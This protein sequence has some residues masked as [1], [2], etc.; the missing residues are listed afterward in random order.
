[1]SQ[2]WQNFRELGSLNIGHNFRQEKASFLCVF[3]ANRNGES[4]DSWICSGF[5]EK[6]VHRSE[7]NMR[8]QRTGLYP[9]TR[10]PSAWQRTTHPSSD[11]PTGISMYEVWGGLL[12]G[13]VV[14][15]Q[16]TNVP[17]FLSFQTLSGI[18]L[19]CPLRSYTWSCNL[20]WS[21]V[22]EQLSSLGI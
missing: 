12:E 19:P 6:L 16:L 9:I 1:M 17:E 10:T 5:L 2:E 4:W 11:F 22:C 15:K 8:P 3:R 7:G 21:V 13:M 14:F 20:L 18:R